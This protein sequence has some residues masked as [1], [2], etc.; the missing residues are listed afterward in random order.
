MAVLSAA[1][2]RE[3]IELKRYRLTANAAEILG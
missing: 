3:G 2:A 1:L